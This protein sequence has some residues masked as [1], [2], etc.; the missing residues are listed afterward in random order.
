MTSA[1]EEDAQSA[2]ED[3]VDDDD[4]DS[5][6]GSPLDVDVD[7]GDDVLA[8]RPRE[9]VPAARER[10]AP[11]PV[12]PTVS[13]GR[14][15]ASPDLV[16]V[17][18]ACSPSNR[19]E[20]GRRGQAV[21]DDWRPTVGVSPPPLPSPPPVTATIADDNDNETNTTSTADLVITDVA[22]YVREPQMLKMLKI[23]GCLYVS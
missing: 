14:D 21:S 9:V 19:S 2:D 13:D 15:S 23:N 12:E 6:R 20:D 1:D 22:K 8:P 5:Q 17:L 11:R 7:T 4:D 10:T 3:G 18:A 16:D